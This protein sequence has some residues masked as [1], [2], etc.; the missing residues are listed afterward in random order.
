MSTRRPT[1]IAALLAPRCY[2]HPAEGIEIAETHISWVLLA[3]EFAY[4]LKKPVDLGFLDFRSLDARR[5][6][7][8]EEVRLNRRLAP[9]LYLGVVPITGNDEFPRVGGDGPVLDY[10]V[11]MRRFDRGNELARLA[12]RGLIA[13]RHIDGLARTLAR[14]HASAAVASIDAPL[15][16]PDVVLAHCLENFRQVAGSA[17]APGDDAAA[18][19]TRAT[20]LQRLEAWTRTEHARLAPM[21]ESRRSRGFVR[22]CHGDLHLANLV[23]IDDTVVAFDG[24]EFSAALRW[25]DVAADLAFVV[26]DLRRFGLKGLAQRLLDAWLEI[27]GDFEAITLMPFLLVYRA[28]VRAKVASLRAA[29]AAGPAQRRACRD[30]AAAYIA[31]A[32]RCRSTMSPVLL[33]TCGVSGSGKSGLASR[34]L[35]A[36][37]WIRLRSDVERKRLRG[38]EPTQRSTDGHGD[39]IYSHR[40]T[41]ATYARLARLASDLLA[42]GVPVIVDAA[43]LLRS[44]RATLRAVAAARRVPFGIL[45]VQAPRDLLERRI[46]ER[47]CAGSDPSEATVE[48]LAAQLVAMQPL[49][50]QELACA[51]TVDT[52]EPMDTDAIAASIAA[53]AVVPG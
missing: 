3:G 9:Q 25:T 13:P 16:T 37:D 29:Q 44:Q 50:E 31:L 10:A 42:A 20:R 21:M 52:S 2:P 26:M 48:V 38:L 28:M 24:I 22:E 53:R 51:V 14:F 46:R 17:G 6:A 45:A 15:G 33:A 30:E 32:E 1:L 47:A 18:D 41:R 23:L 40:T 27:T 34:L 43:C 19:P 36:G 35:E 4:K 39:S 5:V 11:A 49:S 7:C 8:E 12:R